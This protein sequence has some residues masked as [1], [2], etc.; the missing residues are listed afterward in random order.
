[1]D[2]RLL[3]LVVIILFTVSCSSRATHGEQASNVPRQ[4]KVRLED[5][6]VNYIGE[7]TKEMNSDLFEIAERNKMSSL[8]I[9]SPGG[10]I[11][12]GI[13]LAEWIRDNKIDVYVGRLCGSSCANYVLPA[14]RTVYLSEH[15]VLFWHGSTYQPNISAAII[16]GDDAATLTRKAEKNFFTSVG[17]SPLMTVCGIDSASLWENLLHRLGL[18]Q[19][20]GFDY[21]LDTLSKFGLDNIILLSNRW[22][23][24]RYYMNKKILKA[25]FCVDTSWEFGEAE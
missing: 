11:R 16:R 13:E 24:Q 1:M 2:F 23:R 21:S 7:I 17:V 20:L 25:S 4:G 22:E 18:V 5:G 9:E 8:Y 3:T 6:K 10:E 19:I 14:A 15:S 12:Y